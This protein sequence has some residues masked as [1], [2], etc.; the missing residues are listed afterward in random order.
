MAPKLHKL[1]ATMLTD[2]PPTGQNLDDMNFVT[3]SLKMISDE[4]GIP[5]QAQL[6]KES[7]NAMKLK[8][9]YRDYV[10]SGSKSAA[11]PDDRTALML[12]LK[13]WDIMD[14]WTGKPVRDFFTSLPAESFK[15]YEDL[16]ATQSCCFCQGRQQHF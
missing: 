13:H 10:I 12:A 9:C 8:S 14:S 2:L 7:E 15:A 5:G 6:K 4:R 16:A 3:G 11:A 1:L